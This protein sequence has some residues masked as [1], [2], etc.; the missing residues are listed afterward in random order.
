MSN[1]VN[2]GEFFNRTNKKKKS[3]IS[4]STPVT[5]VAKQEPPIKRTKSYSPETEIWLY[6][7]SGE[8]FKTTVGE[9]ANEYRITH[10]DVIRVCKGLIPS[11]NGLEAT[12]F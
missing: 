2:L 9:A 5:P 6:T 1:T 3:R 10:E 4:S 8:Q 11:A 7:E 12:F